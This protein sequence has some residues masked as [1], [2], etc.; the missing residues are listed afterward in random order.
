MQH[1]QPLGTRC[2]TVPMFRLQFGPFQREPESNQKQQAQ[3][4][5]TNHLLL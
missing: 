4:T 2:M 1:D 3:L 5:V